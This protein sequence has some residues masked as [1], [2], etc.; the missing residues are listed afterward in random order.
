MEAP[1]KDRSLTLADLISS[2][3]L[4]DVRV[5]LQDD[6]CA[7]LRGVVDGPLLQEEAERLVS[8]L[9]GVTAVANQIGL[10]SG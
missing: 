6:G 7:V 4:A 2:E 9:D 1:V 5:L 3:G 8:T 10:P